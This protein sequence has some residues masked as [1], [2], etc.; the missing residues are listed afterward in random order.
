[1]LQQKQRRILFKTTLCMYLYMT[2]PQKEAWPWR[3]VWI[4]LCKSD[5][6]NCVQL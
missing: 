5:V 6:L 1:M 4:K 2:F 3:L